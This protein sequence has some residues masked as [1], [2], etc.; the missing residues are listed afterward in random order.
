VPRLQLQAPLSVQTAPH[1]QPLAP[2]AQVASWEQFR[3]LALLQV[4]LCPA[5][6]TFVPTSKF[7]HEPLLYAA[8]H[9]PP[10]VAPAALVP[11]V[12]EPADPVMPA[13]PPIATPVPPLPALPL[14]A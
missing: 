12:P 6:E 8:A 5:V 3:Q 1:G 7:K 14:P 13:E 9:V 10:P 4:Q 2:G 11:A